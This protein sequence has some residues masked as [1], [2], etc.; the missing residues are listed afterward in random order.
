MLGNLLH[1]IKECQ[2][3]TLKKYKVL[4]H[5]HCLFDL[6]Q[7]FFSVPLSQRLDLALKQGSAI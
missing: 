6:F 5:L 1:E 3:L 4:S 7:T 2:F